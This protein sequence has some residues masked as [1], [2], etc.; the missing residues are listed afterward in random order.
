MNELIVDSASEAEAEEEEVV[1]REPT[2]QPK[3]PRGSLTPFADIASGSIFSMLTEDKTAG[4]VT[5]KLSGRKAINLGA[6]PELSAKLEY[7]LDNQVI[8]QLF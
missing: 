5:R 4:Y 1:S 6:D 7:E 3:S 8:Q 2:P